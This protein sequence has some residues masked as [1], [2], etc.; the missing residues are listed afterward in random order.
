MSPLTLLLPLAPLALVPL[1]QRV[2]GRAGLGWVLL[3]V[4]AALSF[5]FEAGLPAAALVLPWVLYTFAAA[6]RSLLGILSRTDTLFRFADVYLAAGAF[7]F[8]V[9][10]S[11]WAPFAM[12]EGVV[13][14]AAIHFHYSGYAG[15]IFAGAAER[16]KRSAAASAAGWAI[17]VAT[18]VMVAAQ[19]LIPPVALIAATI[20]TVAV[21]VLGALGLILARK[22]AARVLLSIAAASAVIALSMG[23]VI[24]VNAAR[25]PRWSPQ[26]GLL[27]VHGFASA[28]GFALAG[29]A[30]WAIER[31]LPNP[32]AARPS[33]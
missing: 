15:L 26:P 28:L 18:P 10:R 6:T 27:Y 7:W 14:L 9:A 31:P 2:R 17:L 13:L 21:A 30:G 29:L 5:A 11:D 1:G 23:A 4:P 3:A 24:A 22:P 20:L 12:T 8:A 19:W 25:D 16:V 33:P 32:P